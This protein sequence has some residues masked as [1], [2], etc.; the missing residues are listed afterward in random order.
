[1]D[2]DYREDGAVAAGILF[3]DWQSDQVLQQIVSQIDQVQP[4]QS[5]QFYK[6]E[7]P[8]LIQLIDQLT[9]LPTTFVVDGFVFLND[10]QKMGSGAYL[11]EHYGRRI[12]VIGVAK[13]VLK[14]TRPQL[15]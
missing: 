11:W 3:N 6:R 13:S 15:K 1:M 14:A 12:P 7:L 5:G 8:C 9:D 10:R 2:V 4:Y